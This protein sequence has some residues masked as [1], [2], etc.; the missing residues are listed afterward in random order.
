MNAV[1]RVVVGLLQFATLIQVDG[2]A[3]RASVDM[4]EVPGSNP[5][6]TYHDVMIF[7]EIFSIFVFLN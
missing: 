4:P 6:G 7:F 5:G 2:L 3:V 1:F